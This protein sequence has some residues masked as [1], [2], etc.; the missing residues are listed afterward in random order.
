MTY[1][2][3][4]EEAR[5][6]AA[7]ARKTIARLERRKAFYADQIANAD[8]SIARTERM[9]RIIVGV[10]PELDVEA[11]PPKPLA[12]LFGSDPDFTGGLDSVAYVREGRG[13]DR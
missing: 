12:D 1:P 8:E 10:Y 7:H 4:L 11:P 13:E 5:A 3:D 9:L 2:I 6:D